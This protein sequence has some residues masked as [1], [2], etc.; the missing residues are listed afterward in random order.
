VAYQTPWDNQGGGQLWP[1]PRCGYYQPPSNTVCPQCGL[2]LA[3]KRTDPWVYVAVGCAIAFTIVVL[4]PLIAIIA[5]I[6]LGGQIYD[7]LSGIGAGI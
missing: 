6:F 7:I 5:L 3:K 1:C 4:L 2:Q